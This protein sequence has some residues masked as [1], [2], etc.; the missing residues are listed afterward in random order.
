MRRLC[1]IQPH[2]LVIRDGHIEC[3]HGAAR[4]AVEG[5]E[6]GVYATTTVAGERLAR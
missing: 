6:T 5:D 2:G 4:A 1:T 3:P